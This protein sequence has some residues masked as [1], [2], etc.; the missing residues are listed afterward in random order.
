MVGLDSVFELSIVPKKLT[1]RRVNGSGYAVVTN[2][3]IDDLAIDPTGERIFAR[4]G[5]ALQE[6]YLSRGTGPLQLTFRTVAPKAPNGLQY[7]ALPS[8]QALR[9]LVGWSFAGDRLALQ[10]LGRDGGLVE[11]GQS[12]FS[13]CE[14]HWS[15][16]AALYY[17]DDQAPAIVIRAA[18]TGRVERFDVRPYVV[19]GIRAV[20]ASE[21]FW[22]YVDPNYAI[23]RHTRTAPS[24]AT[25]A[26]IPSSAGRPALAVG[27]AHAYWPGGS[28]LYRCDESCDV[29]EAFLTAP[30]RALN[31]QVADGVI[32]YQL[33]DNSVWAVAE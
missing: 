30:L 9:P 7:Y 32:Y 13:D 28:T 23:V 15:S 20:G 1:V 19:C 31:V 12:A 8:N 21:F 2:P 10:T 22:T 5:D 26:T 33:A 18:D 29:P 27:R 4:V 6:A 17:P 24:L 25:V 16:G 3:A 11:I 14:S